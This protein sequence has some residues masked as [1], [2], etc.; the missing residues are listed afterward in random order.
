MTAE[1]VDVLVVGAGLS[2]IAAGYYLETRCPK[3]SYAILESRSAI[4]GTWDL[5]RYPGVRSDSDMFTL[6]YSFRPW[7]NAKAIA[8]GPAIL[9]YV[10]ETASI[11]G[12][13]QKIRF[14]HR[15]RH[16]TWSSAEA[17]W[18]IEY[19]AAGEEDVRR[20]TCSFL[21]MCTG[22]YDYD[23]GYTPQWP[24]VERFAGLIVHPQ[25]WPEQLDYAGKRVVVIG[26]GATAVTLVPALAEEAKHVTMLQRSPTYIVARP[27]EDKLAGWMVGHLPRKLAHQVTRWRSILFMIYFYTLARRRPD[28]TKRAIMKMTRQELGPDYDVDT[29]FSPHY[30][31]WDQRLCLVPD[32]D[33]FNA[34]K[35]GT[36][37]VVT[38]EIETFTETGIRLRS[39]DELPADIIV[40]ATGLR[41][42]LM[43]GVDLVVDGQPV[44]L[45]ETLSYRGMMYSGVPNLASVFGY[46]NASWTLKCELIVQYVCRLLNYMDERGY[47]ECVAVAPASM[48]TEEPVINLTSGYVMRALD[49]LPRQ[50]AEKPWRTYQNYLRDL[51]SLRFN[52]INDGTMTFSRAGQ[53]VLQEAKSG[54]AS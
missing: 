32:A 6:G 22:Y 30:N 2:G 15:V 40:T 35:A 33:L 17:M 9:Q 16:A 26:S 4:G 13:D 31:P 10:R 11:Y 14:N 25:Q 49:T 34:M 12:I 42:K 45:A 50:G 5:F 48:G 36:A 52:S 38:E 54:Q 1:H 23:Y 43:S 20:M 53:R 19:T 3:K 29:H 39:G 24:G 28:F 8:G 27:S 51:M 47:A 44:N 7:P 21:F 18:T 37:S 41:M 46:T